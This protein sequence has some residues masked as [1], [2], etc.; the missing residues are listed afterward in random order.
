MEAHRSVYHNTQRI[1]TIDCYPGG[2]EEDSGRQEDGGRRSLSGLFRA[3]YVYLNVAATAKE[4]GIK[5]YV[6]LLPRRSGGSFS[7]ST[8]G[9]ERCQSPDEE[10][11][12]LGVVVRP[13]VFDLAN[14]HTRICV[15]IDSDI[16]INAGD[17]VCG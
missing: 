4:T 3:N 8:P 16:L 7:T 14:L 11:Y 13:A 15:L 9:L 17:Y 1:I 6:L 10:Y 5:R 2:Q 12:H